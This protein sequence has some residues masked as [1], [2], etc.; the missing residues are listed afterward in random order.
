MSEQTTT[1][2]VDHSLELNNEMTERRSK[3]AA[4]RAQGNPF[5][6][7]FRRDSLSGDLH[8]EFGDKSAEE[9]V[10]LGKQVKIAGR[11]MTRRIMG[12]ASFATLLD[13]A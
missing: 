3:L 7:D 8:A 13:M 5:P 11:I 2:E 12:K 10:A 9:L 6:N 1:P 4:L